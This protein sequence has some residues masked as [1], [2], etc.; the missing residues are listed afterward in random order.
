M[1]NAEEVV[2]VLT[3]SN[4][5]ITRLTKEELAALLATRSK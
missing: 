1:D 5:A 3:L 2:K 4:V